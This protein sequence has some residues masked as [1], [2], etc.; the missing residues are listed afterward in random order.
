MSYA[1]DE[2]IDNEDID[3]ATIYA[4]LA[5]IARPNGINFNNLGYLL[6]AKGNLGDARQALNQAFESED[7]SDTTSALI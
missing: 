1:V 4:D 3:V 7:S 5:V 2:Y 6:M